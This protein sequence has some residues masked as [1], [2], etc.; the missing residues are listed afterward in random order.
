[1][2]NPNSSQSGGA[3]IDTS[4]YWTAVRD[5]EKPLLPFDAL[6]TGYRAIDVASN[7]PHDEAG[8]GSTLSLIS[9]TM[10]TASK[11]PQMEAEQLKPTQDYSSDAQK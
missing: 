11:G 6:R 8:I 3:R 2:T 10:P 9:P 7:D 5:R 1:M 4:I